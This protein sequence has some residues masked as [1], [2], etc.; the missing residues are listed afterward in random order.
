MNQSEYLGLKLQKVTLAIAEVND[1]SFD[2]EKQRMLKLKA[3]YK[4]KNAILLK[5]KELS[6]DLKAA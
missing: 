1:C 4:I 6:I 5:G 3:L 2:T